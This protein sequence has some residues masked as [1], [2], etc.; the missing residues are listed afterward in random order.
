MFYCDFFEPPSNL[1]RTS[2]NP[3]SNSQVR[4]H[5]NVRVRKFKATEGV[6]IQRLKEDLF[7][8]EAEEKYDGNTQVVK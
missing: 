5:E 7:A 2:N 1:R 4:F 6:V 8:E 3:S